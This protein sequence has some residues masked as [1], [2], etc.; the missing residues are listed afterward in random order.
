ML[1]TGEPFKMIV[2]AT[3]G[4]HAMNIAK[5]RLRPI[6]IT[7]CSAIPAPKDAAQ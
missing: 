2:T 4:W 7:A 3:N 5:I 6:K 1:E